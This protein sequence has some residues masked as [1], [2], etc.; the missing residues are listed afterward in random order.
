MATAGMRI[1]CRISRRRRWTPHMTTWCTSSGGTPPQKKTD[2]EKEGSDWHA[3]ETE[4]S[5]MMAALP[6][7]AHVDRANQ[8][9]GA[10]LRRL[11][12]PKDVYTGIWWYARFPNHY[13][14]DGS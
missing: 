1:C 14:G 10:D 2:A 5:Q 4:T 13:S 8:E 11:K 9:S 3:G 6:N 12:L 7:L